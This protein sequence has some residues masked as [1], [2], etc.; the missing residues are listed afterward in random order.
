M[1]TIDNFSGDQS[2]FEDKVSH[3]HD[4]SY[5]LFEDN[6]HKLEISQLKS[7]IGAMIEDKI[8]GSPVNS[9]QHTMSLSPQ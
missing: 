7:E 2:F 5:V 3:S 1:G 9:Q 6:M 4:K 8:K